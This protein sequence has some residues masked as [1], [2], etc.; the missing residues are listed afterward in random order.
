VPRVLGESWG[1]GRFLMGEVPLYTL[2]LTMQDTTP[3]IETSP[4]RGPEVK[5]YL[6][7]KTPSPPS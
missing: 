5:G 7:L 4:I 6:A 3:P 1:G 2:P